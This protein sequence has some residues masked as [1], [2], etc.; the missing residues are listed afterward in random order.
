[1]EL[2]VFTNTGQTYSFSD[3]TDFKFTTNGFSFN[4]FGKSTNTARHAA[5][6]NTST[7]GYAFTE[8]K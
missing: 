4:Y 3:V 5:F 1:M 6:N 8:D 7:A 2:I